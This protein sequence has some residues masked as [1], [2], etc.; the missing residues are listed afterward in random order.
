MRTAAVTSPSPAYHLGESPRRAWPPVVGTCTVGARRVA[1]APGRR[2]MGAGMAAARDPFSWAA[3]DSDVLQLS[4]STGGIAVS[5]VSGLSGV[6]T[7]TGAWAPGASTE[8]ATI[9]GGPGR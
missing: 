4:G 3:G 1:A 8:A 9:S 7:G 6:A 5:S 2:G